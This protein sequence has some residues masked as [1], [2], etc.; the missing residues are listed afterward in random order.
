[1]GQSSSSRRYLL[2]LLLAL[3][4]WYRSCSTFQDFL[5]TAQIMDGRIAIV[6]VLTTFLH[7]FLLHLFIIC[8]DWNCAVLVVQIAYIDCNSSTVDQWQR[9]SVQSTPS[10][11]LWNYR[12]LLGFWWLRSNLLFHICAVRQLLTSS[13]FLILRFTVQVCE[14]QSLHLLWVLGMMLLCHYFCISESYPRIV[15]RWWELILT[16]RTRDKH[17]LKLCNVEMMSVY[18]GGWISL[19]FVQCCWFSRLASCLSVLCTRVVWCFCIIN[20]LHNLQLLQR[21]SHVLHMYW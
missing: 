8:S 13:F 17:D 2:D 18:L 11:I 5:L 21:F 15:T 20:I 19:N 16:L 7:S 12:W 3:A 9:R 6:H 10:F 14:A 4:W 1:M